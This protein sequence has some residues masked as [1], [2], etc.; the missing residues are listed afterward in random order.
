MITT[1]Q[2]YQFVAGDIDQVEID[3]GI[4]PLR[5]GTARNSLRGV[6]ICFLMEAAWER[7]HAA[8]ITVPSS[9]RG[10][11]IDSFS[12]EIR[13]TFGID[14]IEGMVDDIYS[15]RPFIAGETFP[16][17]A[18][19][20]PANEGTPRDIFGASHFLPAS[21]SLDSSY[22]NGLVAQRM[23]DL[24]NAVGRA[25]R[26]F[27]QPAEAGYDQN[28]DAA[29]YFA[30]L[31]R[32]HDQWTED[33]SPRLWYTPSTNEYRVQDS[34]KTVVLYV[35]VRAT[36]FGAGLY[37]TRYVYKAMSLNA[38]TTGTVALAASLLADAGINRD[39][40]ETVTMTV[41]V[42]YCLYSLTNH[43]LW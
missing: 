35:R 40:Y 32:H 10:R 19:V 3:G 29:N 22:G 12:R 37:V 27:W 33:Y 31:Y 38:E 5:T 13:R 23:A 34:S 17:M 41:S 11:W 14:N 36:N 7:R 16:A 24:F 20:D 43:T 8:E 25:R 4:M 21:F 28:P 15:G 26:F 2:E 39:D 18:V 42:V 1:R 9:H 30:Y 6:D